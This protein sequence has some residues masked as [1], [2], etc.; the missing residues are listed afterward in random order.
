MDIEIQEWRRKYRELEKIHHQALHELSDAAQI[1]KSYEYL[2]RRQQQEATLLQ[3][4]VERA[5]DLCGVR[6]FSTFKEKRMDLIRLIHEYRTFRRR[7]IQQLEE[8][9]Y[10]G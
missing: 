10:L 6:D 7:G 1:I 9:E 4:I 3:K 2:D 5:D 8:L